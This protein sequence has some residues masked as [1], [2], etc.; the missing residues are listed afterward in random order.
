VRYAQKRADRLA[1][2]YR[3]KEAAARDLVHIYVEGVAQFG[4]RQADVYHQRLEQTFQLIA[5]NPRIARERMEIVGP[6]RVHPCGSHVII[7][8]IDELGVIFLRVRHHRE[9]WAT[10]TL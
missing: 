6:V 8:E 1:L 2:T 7:Y 4:P 5:E 3:L 10:D 9:D